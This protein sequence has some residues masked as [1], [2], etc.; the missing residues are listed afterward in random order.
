MKYFRLLI[1]LACGLASVTAA[2]AQITVGISIKDRF[3]L[4]HE[5]IIATATVTNQTGR[6]VTFTDTPQY[7]WFAFR[8]TTDGDRSVGPRDLHYKVPPLLVKAGTTVKRSVDLSRL[9]DLGAFGTYRIQANVYY[10]GLEKFFASKPTHIEITEGR[11][12]W[13][14]T[15]G[16]PEGLP[17]AGQM[18][19]FTLLAH[20]R[21][22]VNTLY[23]RVE[24]K[25]DGS[26]FCTFPMGRLIDDVPPQAAF[27][28]SNNLYVL[29]LVATRAY[30][31]FKIT[32]NGQFAGRTN[33]T[34][35]KTRP[36]LRKTADGALQIVG[37][38]REVDLAQTDKEPAPK[39]SARP[40]GFPA[41]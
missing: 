25:D 13:R 19:T 32:P 37:G 35:P 5:P 33:Y 27:D 36:S 31:L 14:Q 29:Q 15:A 41:N 4:L 12:L 18:R 38:Q 30:S 17:D 16:V 26:V 28:S 11:V 1:L 7:Q 8:I 39:L 23:V 9:Y 20:Q 21:G 2:R 6:D 10:D 22:E 24:D 40:A 3:H 34:A